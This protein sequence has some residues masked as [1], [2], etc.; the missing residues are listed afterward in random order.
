MTPSLN[1]DTKVVPGQKNKNIVSIRSSGGH[2]Y[3]HL[4]LLKDN[5]KTGLHVSILGKIFKMYLRHT[6]LLDQH[7]HGNDAYNKILYK[8]LNTV[9]RYFKNEKHSDGV[10]LEQFIKD[11]TQGVYQSATTAWISRE[12]AK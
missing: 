10:Q 4:T 2:E 12:Q 7:K 6:S 5:V 9:S 11:F 3:F 1:F 8:F